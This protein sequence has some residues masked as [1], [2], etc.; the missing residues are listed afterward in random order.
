MSVPKPVQVSPLKKRFT[1]D[2]SHT[3]F[4]IYISQVFLA[5]I[6][7]S[8]FQLLIRYYVFLSY[9]HYSCN[10]ETYFVSDDGQTTLCFKCFCIPQMHFPAIFIHSILISTKCIPF[11]KVFWGILESFLLLVL[12]KIFYSQSSWFPLSSYLI[13]GISCYSK[14][15]DWG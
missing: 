15:A 14:S 3:Q 7:P 1:V 4:R 2:F 8:A 10:I 12:Y 6:P 11:T 9:S 5:K 13:S